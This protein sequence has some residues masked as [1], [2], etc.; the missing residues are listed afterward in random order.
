MTILLSK[1]DNKL[2]NDRLASQMAKDAQSVTS[3]KG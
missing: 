1:F 3:S 2:A